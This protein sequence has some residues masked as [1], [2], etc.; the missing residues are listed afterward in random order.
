MTRALAAI[1]LACCALPAGAQTP[2]VGAFDSSVCSNL[3]YI[4]KH[5][6]LLQ[7]CFD[8]A[9]ARGAGDTLHCP[10][11]GRR[12]LDTISNEFPTDVPSPTIIRGRT[13]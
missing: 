7:Q 6:N 12:C 4:N 3:D 8:A 5:Q 2:T 1:I 13:R 10:K 11:D 9:Q